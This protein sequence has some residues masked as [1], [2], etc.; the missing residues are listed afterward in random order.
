MADE[1][2]NGVDGAEKVSKNALK[3]Q[4]KA[5]AA[6]AKKAEKDAKKA[7]DAAAAGPAKKKAGAEEEELDP[8]QYHANRV[9]AI[10]AMETKG[11]NPYPH[12][13]TTTT[14]LPAF[15][16]AYSSMEAGAHGT[17]TVS[18]AGR[19]KTKRVQ[20]KL[21]FYDMSGDGASVQIMSSLGDYESEEAFWE[22]HD[23]LRRGDIVGVTGSPGKS[24]KGELSIF[25][26]RITLLSPC[27]HMLPKG[28]SGLKNQ[29]VRYRQRY[30]DLIMNDDV[31]RVFEVRS[32]VV[33]GIRTFLNERGFLE[34]ETPMMNMIPGGATARPF[35]T[36][37]NELKLDMFMRI[38]PELYLKMLV[39]GGLDRVYEIGR[40]F[41]NEGIDLTHNP[42]FTT[43][44]F[45]Q[46][47]ADYNDL[48]DMTEAMISGMV[49]NICGSYKIKY[50]PS[51]NEEEVEID[52]TPP[53]KRVSMVSGLE[54]ILKVKM[55]ALDDP[56]ADTVL[57]GLI[58]EHAIE[59]P[60]PHTTARMLD[61]LVGEFLE[62]KCI[63]PTFICDH[64]EIMSPLAKYH[65]SLPGMTERFELF[66]CG[67]ELCNAYTELNHPGVQRSRFEAQAAASAQGDDEAQ[68]HDEDFC[69]A[70]EYGLPPTGGWGVGVDRLTMFLSN[71]NNIKE[72]LLFPAMKPDE[73]A[74]A[75]AAQRAAKAHRPAVHT[76][77]QVQAQAA[78]AK[79]APAIATGSQKFQGVD[80][81]TE[82]GLK[83]LEAAL[84]GSR[85]LT[86][87]SPSAEDACVYG[88]VAKVPAQ[89]L[90]GYHAVKGWLNTCALFAPAARSAWAGS[91]TP[92]ASAPAAKAPATSKAKAAAEDG[93]IDD[94][95]GDDDGTDATPAA[96]PAAKPSRAEAMAAAKAAKDKKKKVERSQVVLE[97]KPWDSETDLKALWAKIKAEVT[98]DGLVWA[99]GF[100]IAPVAFGIMK[101]VIS[102]VIE[103]EKVGLDD[104]TDPI[105]EMSDLVQSTQLVSM[106]RYG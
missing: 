84:S 90:K 11:L 97:V 16:A 18:L 15:V 57:R 81:A 96:Q 46:A 71:K 50:Q 63:H 23:L 68:V 105:E 102:C 17:G 19:I 27:L 85:F 14:S 60:P 52:F 40:Q 92:A 33:D 74:A 61:A 91:A 98:A 56:N 53:F 78:V 59:L 54:E 1:A 99:E 48:M 75:A 21:Y 22:V 2:A 62:D 13:F 28:H 26:T 47:Y 73:N 64:P 55:P 29:E 3:K 36:H 77:A 101:L 24:K 70:M 87:H 12:K 95:F 94:M 49:K 42:E 100:N 9:K 89:L 72:V 32:K 30:L 20:G 93:D 66:V 25:P 106:Q 41:R 7:A 82:S 31:R 37:H 8:T 80:F 35:V 65:R 44:E 10:T 104:I 69:V 58:K 4:Q 6:A 88:V 43:C 67:R 51:P 83:Q 76:A 45:Y 38:A 79:C 86:G 34:V 5:D 39:I 103:D